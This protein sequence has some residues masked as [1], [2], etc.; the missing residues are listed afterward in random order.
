MKTMKFRPHLVREIQAGRK[1][2]TWRLFDDKDLKAGDSV[3]LL[4]WE[5][6]ARFALAKII[7]V[8]EKPLKLLNAA[9]F[10][11]HGPLKT[12]E[13]TV[14]GFREY[15]GDKVTAETPVKIVNFKILNFLS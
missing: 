8:T 1:T 11:E 13:E 15:Y 6:K 4:D 5:T 10:A 14:Q 3:E 2:V 9:D 7:A 12:I